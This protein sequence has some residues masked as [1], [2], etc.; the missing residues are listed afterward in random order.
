[1][2]VS[3][4]YD[5]FEGQLLPVW[6][7]VRPISDEWDANRIL[8]HIDAPFE[9]KLGEEL[10]NDLLSVSV[11][12]DDLILLEDQTRTL[13][14]TLDRLISKIQA[15]GYHY[16]DIDQLLLQICD[17]EEVLHMDLRT[18]YEWRNENAPIF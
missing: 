5:Y 7:I 2:S 4:Y 18:N 6:M 8:I 10:S 11:E 12:L 3:V 13:C 14:I 9:R 1:M 16:S 17:V 15:A